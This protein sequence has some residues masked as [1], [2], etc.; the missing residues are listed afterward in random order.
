[1]TQGKGTL[2]AKPDHLSLI[3]GPNGSGETQTSSPKKCPLQASSICV[4][5]HMLT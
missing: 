5:R 1:M 3:L 4:A 2:A